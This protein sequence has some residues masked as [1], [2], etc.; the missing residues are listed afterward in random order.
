MFSWYVQY[1]HPYRGHVFLEEAVL[2]LSI[3]LHLGDYQLRIHFH[4][5]FSGA[6]GATVLGGCRGQR[7][8]NLVWSATSSPSLLLRLM[9][10][11]ERAIFPKPGG[12][13]LPPSNMHKL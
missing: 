12:T 2:H 1:F 7:Y 13:I 5:I 8:C 11:M 4:L 6:W 3:T 9:L 10:I